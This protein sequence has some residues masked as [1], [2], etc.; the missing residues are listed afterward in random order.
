MGKRKTIYD[1]AMEAGVSTATVSRV[2]SGKGYVSEDTRQKVLA[3]SGDYHPSSLAAGIRSSRSMTIGI[4]INHKPDYFFLNTIY[5]SALRAI[6]VVLKEYG[7]RMML[8]IGEDENESLNLYYEGKVDGLLLMGV[9]QSSRLIHK[10]SEEKIP[11]VL[12]GCYEAEGGEKVAQ[13][14]IN[15]RMAAKKAVEHL[16]YLGH[17]KIGIIS[18]SMEYASCRNRIEGYKD[19]LNSAN[20]PVNADYIKVCDNLSTVMAEHLAK[21]LLFSPDSITAIMC[22]NDMVALSVYKA[23]KSMGIRI[24]E[25]LSIIGFDD[26]EI[27]AYAS[28]PLTTVWQPGYEKGEKAARM[29]VTALQN[30]TVP[31]EKIVLNCVMIYRESC[32]GYVPDKAG[33]DPVRHIRKALTD[34]SF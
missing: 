21:E 9:K 31:E 24:P 4:I 10:M 20:L 5:L 26:S 12:I 30:N 8:D 18:G 22:F 28:P 2:I 6:S 7:Y 32:A 3:A 14:D 17:K 13:V 16:I 23:A 19:A 27:A 11:F 1:V 25:Q 29:L 33:P 15:D 34:G